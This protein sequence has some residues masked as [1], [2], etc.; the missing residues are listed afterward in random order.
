MR[1]S[2]PSY[3]YSKIL[4][5]CFRCTCLSFA[6]P[7]IMIG[8]NWPL[9]R[10]APRSVMF[11]AF[12]R[13]QGEYGVCCTV[14]SASLLQLDNMRKLPG[15]RPHDV[16]LS[17]F[18]LGPATTVSCSAVRVIIPS[19]IPF[20][21]CHRR[22]EQRN[23]SHRITADHDS[24][25]TPRPYP[26]PTR[27]GTTTAASFFPFGGSPCCSFSI[28]SLLAPIWW[29]ARTRIWFNMA[30]LLEYFSGLSFLY[31]YI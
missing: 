23:V 28:S 1:P 22:S 17:P 21:W 16:S 26:F 27:K 18:A 24:L 25:I 31:Q 20:S 11:V 2:R 15:H 3:R 30:D 14:V 29:C 13:G 19:S 7:L 4:I 5:R 6:C 9:R 8:S 10:T 12:T